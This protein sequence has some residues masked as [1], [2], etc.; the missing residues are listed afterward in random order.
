M[1]RGY[2]YKVKTLFSQ[3]KGEKLYFVA[4]DIMTCYDSFHSRNV[5]ILFKI[6]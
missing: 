6:Y 1:E 4:L 2:T 3:N 5:L